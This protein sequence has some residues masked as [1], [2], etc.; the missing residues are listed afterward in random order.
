M[1]SAEVEE[2][3]VKANVSDELWMITPEDERSK[4]TF[5]KSVE[6][7]GRVSDGVERQAEG[8]R[9]WL[10]FVKGL[11][12]S[13]DLRLDLRRV[14]L[15]RPLHV[16]DAAIKLESRERVVECERVE[17]VHGVEVERKPSEGHGRRSVGR[18]AGHAERGVEKVWVGQRGGH[19]VETTSVGRVRVRVSMLLR[20]YV[21]CEGLIRPRAKG[22][23]KSAG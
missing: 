1:W 5:T 22:V 23:G 14:V 4:G 21:S 3:R 15:R 6:L 16:A 19:S 20:V 10:T 13:R 7:Q 17:R 12:E 18:V 11:V 2:V 9:V 8:M